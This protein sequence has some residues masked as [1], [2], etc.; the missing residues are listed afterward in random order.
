LAHGQRPAENGSQ[1]HGGVVVAARNVPARVDHD[2]RG[3]ADRERRHGGAL[4]DDEPDREDEEEGAD[5]LHQVR[6]H[7]LT[8]PYSEGRSAPS[9]MRG[10]LISP[11]AHGSGGR[12]RNVGR[13]VLLALP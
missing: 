13:E 5:E 11:V 10:Y 6:T 9:W 3:K 7:R 2:H 8:L 4:D 12:P 1:A